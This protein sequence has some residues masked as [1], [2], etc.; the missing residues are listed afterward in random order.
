MHTMQQMIT[1]LKDLEARVIALELAQKQQNVVKA[2]QA[3]G[4]QRVSNT[5]YSKQM[6]KP[7]KVESDLI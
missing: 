7:A 1:A 4:L 2:T 3:V 5:P 6:K